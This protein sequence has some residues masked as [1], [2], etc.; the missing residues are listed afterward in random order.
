MMNKYCGCVV[1]L[2]KVQL[3]KLPYFLNDPLPTRVCLRLN[4]RYFV[5]L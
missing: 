4:I 1:L 2:V 5:F 3:G